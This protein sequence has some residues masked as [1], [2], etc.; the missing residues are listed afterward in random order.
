MIESATLPMEDVSLWSLNVLLQSSLVAATALFIA[1]FLNQRPA[2][3]YSILCVGL[4][5]L[6]LCPMTAGVLQ[7][8]R[9]GWITLPTAG[10]VRPGVF[11]LVT[12]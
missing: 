7:T 6:F 3:R 12:E 10:D 9:M 11:Y 2:L 8:A 1:T 5:L 4:V